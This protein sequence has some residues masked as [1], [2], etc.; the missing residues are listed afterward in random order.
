MLECSSLVHSQEVLSLCFSPQLLSI[1]AQ[2]KTLIVI[3]GFYRGKPC[4][5]SVP[6]QPFSLALLKESLE[7]GK[8]TPARAESRRGTSNS[9]RGCRLR[10]CCSPHC[11]PKADSGAVDMGGRQTPPFCG[12]VS[13]GSLSVL[14]VYQVYLYKMESFCVRCMHPSAAVPKSK[15]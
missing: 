10:F 5:G 2:C 11:P 12:C 13:S 4:K 8:T 1:P 7:E 9:P 15:V 3:R 14:G 6:T